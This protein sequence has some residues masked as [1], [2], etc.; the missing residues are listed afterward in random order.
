MFSNLAIFGFGPG[1][2]Y[3]FIFLDITLSFFN[4][5]F[6]TNISAVIHAWHSDSAV[7]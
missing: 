7:G 2:L 4:V 3:L 1:K 5:L 6:W